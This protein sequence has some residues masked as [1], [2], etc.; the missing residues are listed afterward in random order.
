MV[1]SEAQRNFVPVIVSCGLKYPF[2]LHGDYCTEKLRG[3]AQQSP[4]PED[5]VQVI[6]FH[7][8][9]GSILSHLG[10]PSLEAVLGPL[11]FKACCSRMQETHPTP[12]ET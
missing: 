7:G 5:P 3:S 10:K 1:L 6:L 2:I 8:A 12:S 11:G 4:P 9:I